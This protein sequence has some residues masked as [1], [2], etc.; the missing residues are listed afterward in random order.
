MQ[1][2]LLKHPRLKDSRDIHSE[3]WKACKL[4]AQASLRSVAIHTIADRQLG[5]LQMAFIQAGLLDSTEDR[6]VVTPKPQPDGTI[7]IESVFNRWFDAPWRAVAS[8]AWSVCNGTKSLFLPD[9][10]TETSEW[11]DPWTVYRAFHRMEAGQSVHSNFVWKYYF[12]ND[13]DVIVWRSVLD[14]ALVPRNNSDGV[15][16]NEWGCMIVLVCMKTLYSYC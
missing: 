11:I 7:I 9:D 3:A 10:A 13:R 1:S 6:K 2:V 14:D 8:A 15:I 16:D 5:K 4:A 12:E